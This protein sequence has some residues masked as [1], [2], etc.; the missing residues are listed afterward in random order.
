MLRVL[1]VPLALLLS[2][3]CDS[4]SDDLGRGRF[5]AT[6]EGARALDL[7]GRAFAVSDEAEPSGWGLLLSSTAADA[8]IS[9]TVF[10]GAPR[11]GTLAVG[12]AVGEPATASFGQ[13]GES[14]SVFEADGGTLIVTS[15]A[16]DVVAGSIAFSAE[17]EDGPERV[18]VDA[19]FRAT[20]IEAFR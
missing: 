9:A 17:S 5:T 19:T 13:F 18:S 11:V 4:A 6:V 16:G 15:V 10:D 3:G 12:G 20:I 7:R 8:V 2:A 1:A 14:L